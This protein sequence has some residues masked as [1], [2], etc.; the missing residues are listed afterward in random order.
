[1]ENSYHETIKRWR[2]DVERWLAKG[3]TIQKNEH[4]KVLITKKENGIWFRI[5][6]SLTYYNIPTIKTLK[7]LKDKLLDDLSFMVSGIDFYDETP[8]PLPK[9]LR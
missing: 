8:Y 5:D 9:I 3:H 2:S 1:M 6:K 7:E 4:F